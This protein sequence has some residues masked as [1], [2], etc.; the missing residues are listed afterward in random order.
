MIL[1]G[2]L[3]RLQVVRLFPFYIALRKLTTDITA[4]KFMISKS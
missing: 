1:L 4:S 2:V 3:T